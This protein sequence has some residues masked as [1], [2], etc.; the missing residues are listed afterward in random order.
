MTVA[1]PPTGIF[2]REPVD[3]DDLHGMLETQIQRHRKMAVSGNVD[4]TYPPYSF[5]MEAGAILRHQEDYR[6][7]LWAHRH[8][9]FEVYQLWGDEASRELFV[10]LMLYRV[11]GHEHVKLPVNVPHFW[12]AHG[13]AKALPSSH[14]LMSYEPGGAALLHFSLAWKGQQLELDCLRA[15]VLFSF[16]LRQYHLERD[17]V[18]ISPRPGDHVIDVGAC[19]GDTAIDFACAAGAEGRVH[20]FDVVD[21]HLNVLRNNARQNA[22]GAAIVVHE[23][24]LSDVDREGSIAHAGVQPGFEVS[25]DVQIRLSRLDS[26]VEAGS[27][28][29]VDFIKMDIEGHEEAALRGATL[30]LRRFR[31]RLAIS[32]Y[33]RWEDYHRLPMLVRNLGLGYRL[34]LDNYTI[35][36]GETVMYGVA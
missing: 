18:C 16:F 35:S 34:Y 22:A 6:R 23:C 7:Y 30:V 32:M 24:G 20:C 4:E 3:G 9:L 31:P 14:S 17:G 1:R 28:E 21:T 15:N 10:H 25:G 2:A 19:F 33:H 13:L 36:D 26:L 27:I 8:E 29:R 5:S 12:R 11:L